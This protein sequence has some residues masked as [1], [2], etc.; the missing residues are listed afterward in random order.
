MN[1]EK[2]IKSFKQN[3]YEVSY[4]Q[5]T[6]EAKE[7]LNKVIDNQD[8]GFGDSETITGMGLYSMLASHNEVYDPQNPKEGKSFIDMAT[9]CYQSKIYILSANAVSENG[10][11]VNI[12]GVGN[13]I[14]CSV[15]G[16]EKVYFIIGT[17]KIAPTLEDAIWRARNVAAPRN[18]KRIG[19]K[20]PCAKDGNKCYDC[21]SPNRICNG[22]MVYLK[23]MDNIEMEIVII[24][25]K[26]G[27]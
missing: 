6:N 8:V 10:E 26:L 27:L 12:D 13:R 11:M 25:E 1:I 3:G 5:S 21:K 20:T 23:K 7:Y 16:H 17:N 4:F 9:R 2:T 24:E 18:A 19:Y 15:F 14:G 22:M